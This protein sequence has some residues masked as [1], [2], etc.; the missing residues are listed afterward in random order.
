[1]QRLRLEADSATWSAPA[2]PLAKRRHVAFHVAIAAGKLARVEERSDHGESVSTLVDEVAADLLIYA[3]QLAT[4]QGSDLGEL[5]CRRVPSVPRRTQPWR[6]R[7]IATQGLLTVDDTNLALPLAG[8]EEARS[9]GTQEPIRLDSLD[10]AYRETLLAV[11][12]DGADVPAVG[13]K[14]VGNGILTRERRNHSLEIPSA[15]G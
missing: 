2:E 9:A 6:R 13:G 11:L 8:S 1:M 5:Y 15:V 7:D 3:L 4:I 12:I 14:S 10:L